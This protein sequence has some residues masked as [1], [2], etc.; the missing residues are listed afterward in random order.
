MLKLTDAVIGTIDVNCFS[1]IR[2]LAEQAPTILSRF[3][4]V[5][6]TSLDS[7]R[8]INSGVRSY[9]VLSKFEVHSNERS[10]G[11][12]VVSGQTVVNA[13]LAEN[14]F[15][16]FDE[17]W[18]FADVPPEELPDTLYL[19]TNQWMRSEHYRADSDAPSLHEIIRWMKSCGAVCGLSD[20]VCLEYV[21]HDT[22]LAGEIEACLMGLSEVSKCP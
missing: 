20:G 6:I 4:Y 3:P 16:G 2:C 11:K 10:D 22:S 8:S 21:T 17:I 9:S 14:F 12:I 7:V 13:A 19:A 5:W 18:L 1:Y 15:N